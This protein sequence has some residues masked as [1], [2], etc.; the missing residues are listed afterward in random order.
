MK[1][2]EYLSYNSIKEMS[3]LMELGYLF[4]RKF[5]IE[6]TFIFPQK[7]FEI[8][9]LFKFHFQVYN[10]FISCFTIKCYILH[11][12]FVNNSLFG[13]SNIF[14]SKFSNVLFD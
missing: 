3:H 14:F 2:Y 7:C 12:I 4:I 11:K 5:S 13:N 10:F 9:N 1:I 6:E 8:K